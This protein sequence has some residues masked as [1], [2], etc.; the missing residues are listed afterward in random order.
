MISLFTIRSSRAGYLILVDSNSVLRRI[1]DSS[2]TRLSHWLSNRASLFE[3][4][5][6]VSADRQKANDQC[7]RNIVY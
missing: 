7:E 2:S 6:Q 5:L 1:A 4:L 3:V